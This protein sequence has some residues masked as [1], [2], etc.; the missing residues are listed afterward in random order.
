MIV[1]V[2]SKDNILSW[3]KAKYKFPKDWDNED[4]ECFALEYMHKHLK[5]DYFPDPKHDTVY[6]HRVYDNKSR[7]YEE[8]LNGSE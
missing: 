8:M 2:W 3:T 4:I 6:I 7:T 5:A 1:K